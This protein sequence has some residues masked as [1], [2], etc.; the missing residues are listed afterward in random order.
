MNINDDKR[1]QND[2]EL[3]IFNRRLIWRYDMM[4]KRC[5]KPY[6]RCFEH[7]GGRGI[8]VCE[9]WL[10]DKNSFIKWFLEQPNCYNKKY[11][12][13]RIDNNGN[14]SPENCRLADAKTQNKNRGY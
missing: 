10:N 5:S 11:T 9:E 4:I 14:Y 8:K 3:S 1:P 13:D 12:I 6:V 2:H 7:Y